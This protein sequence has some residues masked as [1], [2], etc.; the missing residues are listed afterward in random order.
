MMCIL[1]SSSN[2]Q[3]YSFIFG[4]HPL[5]NKNNEGKIE[6]KKSNIQEQINNSAPSL[7]IASNSLTL[8]AKCQF[9]TVYLVI[10][11]RSFQSE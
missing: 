7:S 4:H 1:W 8:K 11:E 2:Q 9:F 3:K 10:A 6:S 5:T